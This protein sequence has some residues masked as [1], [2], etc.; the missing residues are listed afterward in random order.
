MASLFRDDILDRLK[1]LDDDANSIF[2]SDGRFQVVIVGGGALVLHGYITR[3]TDDIDI[4]D[5]NH[6]LHELMQSYDMNGD[7]NAY[8]NNFP[9]NYEDRTVL[10]WSGMK[11]DYY[12]ASLEDIVISKLCSSRPDDLTDIE[13]LV[14]MID[15]EMLEKLALDEHEIK[16]SSLNESRYNDFLDSYGNY[17]RRFR[18]CKDYR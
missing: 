16:A 18:P 9:Y 7:V 6:K 14:D 17:K 8:I 15:W 13:F 11:I 2:D 12:A 5:A 4:L 1:Y 10:V 3:G